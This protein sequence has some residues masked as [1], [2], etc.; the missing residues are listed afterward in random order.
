MAAAVRRVEDHQPGRAGVERKALTL[1]WGMR[2]DVQQHQCS[3]AGLQRA[4]TVLS[5]PPRV[6]LALPHWDPAVPSSG[7]CE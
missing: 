6:R 4:D 7:G 3:S 2:E 5:L 1:S